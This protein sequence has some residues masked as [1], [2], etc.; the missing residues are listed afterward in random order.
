[1]AESKTQQIP[2][3]DKFRETTSQIFELRRAMQKIGDRKKE[4]INVIRKNN[5]GAERFKKARDKLNAQVKEK[6]K[7]R[8]K[9]NKEIKA[10]FAEYNKIKVNFP[11]NN[12]RRLE[13]EIEQL[14]WRQQTTV[15]KVD[16]EDELVKRLETLKEEMKEYKDIAAI[17]KKIDKAKAKSEKIHKK[18]LELSEKSQQQHEK[19]VEAVN[20]IRKL[21]AKIDALN[22][23]RN[24][25][26]SKLNGLTEVA[27]T[28]N[29]TLKEKERKIKKARIKAK[30]KELKEVETELKKNAEAAY[31]RFKK[32]EKLGTDDLYLLQRFNLV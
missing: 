29:Q 2:M 12:F 7:E 26:V 19:F 6:K 14:E 24:E 23:E 21:E 16:K 1:M 13:R 30:V 17:S 10:L 25:A 8:T 27:N 5:F 22:K 31:E 4:L 28:L 20:N 9:I 11:K 3:E 15:L 32:G 18:I